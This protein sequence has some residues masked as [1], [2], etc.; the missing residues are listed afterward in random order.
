MTIDLMDSMNAFA[1]VEQ[2][3]RR[4]NGTKARDVTLAFVFVGAVDSSSAFGLVVV[5][6]LLVWIPAVLLRVSYCVSKIKE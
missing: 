5:H 4:S 1:C 6:K 2:N 3:E